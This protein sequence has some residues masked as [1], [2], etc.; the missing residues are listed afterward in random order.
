MQVKVEIELFVK[1]LFEEVCL[2]LLMNSFKEYVVGYS[3]IFYNVFEGIFE[4][5]WE[6]NED[7]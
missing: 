2:L 1:N 4:V 3:E 6:M 5:I 7:M